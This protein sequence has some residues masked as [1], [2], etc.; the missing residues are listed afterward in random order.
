MAGPLRAVSDALP[1]TYAVDLGRQATG[2]PGVT[3]DAVRDIAI[4]GVAVAAAVLLAAAT[5]RRQTA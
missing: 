4:L 1:L 5:L 2:P 3:G